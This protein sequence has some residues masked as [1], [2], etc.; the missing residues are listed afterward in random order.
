[1]LNK[2]ASTLFEHKYHIV[3]TTFLVFVDAYEN[4]VMA[5]DV[6]TPSNPPISLVE[7]EELEE[8]LLD[9]NVSQRSCE[10]E[11]SRRV[12]R[13][14]INR[15]AWDRQLFPNPHAFAIYLEFVHAC[16]AASKRFEECQCEN[17]NVHLHCRTWVPGDGHYHWLQGPINPLSMEHRAKYL[18]RTIRRILEFLQL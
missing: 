10:K 3:S 16:G 9:V 8:A 7:K 2:K 15:L 13:I 18:A 1:L 12:V 5:D 14:R 17:D 11:P 4:L 6:V